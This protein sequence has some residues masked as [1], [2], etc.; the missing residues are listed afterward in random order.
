MSIGQPLNRADGILKVTGGALYSA[1]IAVENVAYG[2]MIQSTVG[3]GKIVRIDTT[4][5]ERLEGIVAILTPDNAEKLPKKGKA[6]FSPPAGRILSLLQDYDVHYNGQP[7]GVVVA[8]TLEQARHAA[9]LVRYEYENA[10]VE[11]DFE[12][13]LARSYPYADKILGRDPPHTSRGDISRALRDADACID[14]VYR[15]PVETHN[16]IEPHAT[17]AQWKGDELTLYDSTQFVYG[18]RRVVARTFGMPEEKIH[19]VS[20]FAG[21]AFGS[22]GAAWSH[23]VLA[24]MA[25]RHAKRPVKIVLTRRQMFGPVG[26]RP[27]TTQHFEMGAMR[28]GTLCAMRHTATSSTSKIEE[29]VEASTLATRI[30]YAVPNQSTSQNLVKLNTGTPT[31]NRAPGEA[32][33]TYA[34]E[35]AMDE[36]AGQLGIDPLELRLRNYADQ[37]PEEE[38]PWSSKSL[39]E[40]YETAAEKFS[41]KHRNPKP[42]SMREDGVLIG[43]GM[44]TA[45]YPVKQMP[46]SAIARLTPEGI[47]EIRAATHE[48]GTGTRTVMPQIAAEVLRIPVERIRLVLGDTSL[49]QNP[50]SAGSMTATSTGS[51]VHNAAVA[52]RD[53]LKELG[54]TDLASHRPNAIVEAKADAKPDEEAQKKY[55]MHAFGAVFVEV[56]VDPDLGTIRV[57]RVAGAYG[58]GRILNPKTA[59]SQIIGGIIYGI[60]MALLED[61]LIDPRNGRYLNAELDE[62]HLPVHADV[63]AIDVTFVDEKDEHVNPIGVKG[64]GEIGITGV[65]A[66]IANAVYHATGVRV[67]DLPIT[68]DKVLQL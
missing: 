8:E 16:P 21:G 56:R 5:A 32:S 43:M 49:P 26:A 12:R 10:E 19:V 57:S 36:M 52:L 14:V 24:A 55:S 45:T 66:A 6:A 68:L 29:W 27:F 42:R 60:G 33:G 62:Y 59:R 58:G 18:V 20:Q 44:A 11:A 13:A 50:I 2:M 22:K 64:I 39:R 61:T 67:R 40:C 63:P 17:I 35:S 34:L 51:A 23:V 15:T 31:F 54:V 48:I 4:D 65:A 53:M 28:D 41:W 38:K 30:L 7:V 1:E 3:A 46:A 9:A 47:V 37:D 25:A